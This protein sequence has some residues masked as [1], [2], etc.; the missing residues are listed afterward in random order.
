MTIDAV[1]P[2]TYPFGQLVRLMAK[3][4]GSRARLLNGPPW[5]ALIASRLMGLA[6][7]DVM[8]TRDEL[9]GLMSNLLVSNSAPTGQT[10][11]SNW[12]LANVTSLGKRYA[13][14]I[15]RHYSS[16]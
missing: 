5:L 6:L 16:T 12:I 13:S 2:E 14:E 4:L 10:L 8:L 11:F 1:G 15:G 7:A 9:Q 3:I